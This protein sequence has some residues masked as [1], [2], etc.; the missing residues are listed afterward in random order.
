MSRADDGI[1]RLL[2]PRASGSPRSAAT[3]GTVVNAHQLSAVLW[4]HGLN[5]RDPS[6]SFTRLCVF[7]PVSGHETIFVRIWNRLC[8]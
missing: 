8:M 2:A 7:A 4:D 5:W 3:G 6:E 1:D